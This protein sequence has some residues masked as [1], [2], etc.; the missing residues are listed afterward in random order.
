VNKSVAF[1]SNDP[2]HP[3][4]NLAFSASIETARKTVEALEE[5]VDLGNLLP[6]R[7]GQ[8]QIRLTNIGRQPYRLSLADWPGEW[9][10]ADWKERVIDPGDT[11]TLTV[12][13]HGVPPLGRFDESITFDVEGKEKSRF[14]LP[15]TGIGLVE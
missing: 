12:G 2:E 8:A 4:A 10:E 11:L 9:L 5:P 7:T 14:S 1:Y 3:E 15:I 6:N 13:T